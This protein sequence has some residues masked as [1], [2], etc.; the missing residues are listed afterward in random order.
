MRVKIEIFQAKNKQW[1]FHVTRG[2]RIVLA[3]GETYLTRA[4]AR[5]ALAGVAKMCFPLGNGDPG[6]LEEACYRADTADR[7][8]QAAA[9][10][11]AAKK[12]NA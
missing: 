5:R 8:A 3:A 9:K 11:V 4:N 1:T 10:K 6:A 12:V 7:L 2:A